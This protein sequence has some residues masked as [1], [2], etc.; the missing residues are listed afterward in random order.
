MAIEAVKEGESI[1][2]F[3]DMEA[4]DDEVAG[5]VKLDD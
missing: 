4:D 3:V 5:D 1:L 2:S